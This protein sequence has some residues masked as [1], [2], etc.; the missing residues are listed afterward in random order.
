MQPEA[1]RA[2]TFRMDELI[3]VLMAITGLQ[4]ILSTAIYFQKAI[5]ALVAASVVLVV[6]RRAFRVRR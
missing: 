4:T 3:G 5:V 1:V 2:E 6:A